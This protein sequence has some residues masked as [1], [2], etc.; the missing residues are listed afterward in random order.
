M[1][2]ILLNRNQSYPVKYMI[3]AG[4]VMSSVGDKPRHNVLIPSFRAIFLNPS[5]V[6]LKVL[7]W[8]SSTAHSAPATLT[9]P[10]FG[11]AKQYSALLVAKNTSRQQ[12]VTPRLGGGVLKVCGE[13]EAN[14]LIVVRGDWVG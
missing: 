11:A 7:L 1:G 5:N 9:S 12:A 13:V 10:N 14:L 4:T 6:E 8:V 2:L 3:F